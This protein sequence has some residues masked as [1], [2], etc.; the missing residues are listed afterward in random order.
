M[1]IL[2]SIRAKPPW[3]TSKARVGQINLL[4]AEQLRVPADWPGV[5]EVLSDVTK[6][7]IAES[8]ALAGDRGAYIL[9]LTDMDASYKEVL[10][11]FIR[12]LGRLIMKHNSP[13]SIKKIRDDLAFCMALLEI[14]MPM[15]WNKLA[16]HLLLHAPDQLLRVAAF[17]AQNMLSVERFHVL[18]HN[19]ARGSRNKLASLAN[20]YDLYDVCQTNWRFEHEFFLA[21]KQSSLASMR[22]VPDNDGEVK[23]RGRFAR[24]TSISEDDLLSVHALWATINST[25]DKLLDRYNAYRRKMKRANKTIEPMRRWRPR[26]GRRLTPQEYEWTQMSAMTEVPS[27]CFPPLYVLCYGNYFAIMLNI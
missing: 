22:V 3:T 10:I 8:L 4:C 9:G 26:S 15:Y 21:A 13:D 7:K 16:T 6:M 27:C 19:L 20:K 14:K 24:T 17:W 11:E 5:S 1:N 25:Y 18:L 12:L 2:A 23:R